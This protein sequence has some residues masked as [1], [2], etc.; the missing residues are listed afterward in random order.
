MISKRGQ[1]LLASFE[2]IEEA[3]AFARGIQRG[4]GLVVIFVT[5]LGILRPGMSGG[6]DEPSDPEYRTVMPSTDRDSIHW[7][8]VQRE[9][10]LLFREILLYTVY[11]RIA[12][13]PPLRVVHP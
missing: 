1:W 13:P 6:G 9:S 2:T 7:D 12:A 3:R 10:S 8:E 11:W 4:R 5:V